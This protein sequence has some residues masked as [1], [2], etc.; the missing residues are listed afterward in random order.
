MAMFFFTVNAQRT[1][2]KVADLQRAIVDNIAKEH[3]GFSIKDATMIVENN[4]TSYEVV[5]AKGE[6]KETLL[7]DAEGRFVKKIVAQGGTMTRQLSNSKVAGKKV[8]E[9]TTG[10]K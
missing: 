5:V 6:T 10:G 3:V 4:I 1:Q 8:P 2:V 7:Y 9:K